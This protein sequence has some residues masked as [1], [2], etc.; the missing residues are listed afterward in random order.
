MCETT[1][2]PEENFRGI[3]L[4]RRS[5]RVKDET[6]RERGGGAGVAMAWHIATHERIKPR[7]AVM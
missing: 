1:I 7:Q 6:N 4:V 5:R 2:G 3:S